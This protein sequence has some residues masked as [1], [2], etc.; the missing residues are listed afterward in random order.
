M[1]KENLLILAMGV[2]I[3]IAMAILFHSGPP[4]IDNGI[5]PVTIK[6]KTI[7]TEKNYQRRIDSIAQQETGV[8]LQLDEARK[9]LL[10]AQKN[11]KA[12][13]SR[14]TD[15]MHPAG[16]GK[17]KDTATLL[18]NCDS[19]Q[20]AVVLLIRNDSLRDEAY[21]EIDRIFH[22]RLLLREAEIKAGQER[23]TATRQAYDQSL[24]QL[25][26]T[27]SKLANLKKYASKYKFKNKLGAAAACIV[28][29][30]VAGV[31]LTH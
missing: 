16:T 29:G 3:G 13:R 27:N 31:L 10:A 6:D 21:T 24:A 1:K 18:N 30:L 12:L 22:S 11:N 4:A 19:L 17:A 20:S 23:Y 8:K 28:A 26:M 2:V 15:F 9:R 7:E 14:I 25:E 5:H